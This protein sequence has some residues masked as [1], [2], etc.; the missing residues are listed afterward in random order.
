[1]T[2][3]ESPLSEGVVRLLGRPQ[4]PAA[5]APQVGVFIVGPD[6]RIADAE[7]SACAL[8]GYP[9]GGLV[10]RLLLDLTH[11]DDRQST[12]DTCLLLFG[13]HA[14][15]VNLQKRFLRQDGT[16]VHVDVRV[17]AIPNGEG[18]TTG[19]IVVA[20]PHDE[21][22]AAAAE[23]AGPLAA[24]ASSGAFDTLAEGVEGALQVGLACLHMD[25]A[26]VSRIEGE[27]GRVLASAGKAPPA[28]AQVRRAS[29][30]WAAPLQAQGPALVPDTTVS[31][32]HMSSHAGFPLGSYAGLL[33]TADGHPV[34]VDFLGAASRPAFGV[35]DEEVLAIV[36]RWVAVAVEREAARTRA[37]QLEHELA[38]RTRL[39]GHATAQLERY[40]SDLAL[41]LDS[42]AEGIFG[43]D[44]EGRITFAN[45]A[46]AG[47]LGY[48]VEEL[49]GQPHHALFH[50]SR[51]DGLPLQRAS[52]AILG[53]LGGEVTRVEAETFW[54]KDG[55]ALPVSIVSA[56][57]R[58][59]DRVTGAA[60][61]FNDRSAAV[62]AER[63]RAELVHRLE[64]F[65]EAIP[66]GVFIV[67]AEQRPTFANA[68]AQ[69]LL[70]RDIGEASDFSN[71]LATY[72]AFREGTDL[73]Y[74]REELPMLRALAGERHATCSDLEL[75]LPDRTLNLEVWAEPIRGPDGRLSF[76]VT[77]FQDISERRAD[78][79]RRALEGAIA[80]VLASAADV[81]DALP[82]LLRAMLRHLPFATA[83]FW[84]VDRSSGI[85]RCAE[86]V[87]EGQPRYEALEA[88]TRRATP[89][90][91]SG[92]VGEAWR[93]G[94]P[95]S[96][97][98]EA[99]HRTFSRVREADAAGIRTALA[100]PIL[101]EGETIAV[102][103]LLGPK[104]TRPEPGLL[105]S[106]ATAGAQVGQFLRRA[107]VQAD[108]RAMVE[109][110]RDLEESR[111]KVLKTVAHDL[112]GPL[113]PIRLQLRML[114]TSLGTATPAQAKAFKTIERNLSQMQRLV[115]DVKD[116]ARLQS[117]EITLQPEGLDLCELARHAAE[118]FRAEAESK[119]IRISD[120]LSKPMPVH[121]DAQRMTQVLFNLL[122]NALKFT[123]S[124][125][126]ITVEGTAHAGKATV[127]VRDTGRGLSREES[128]RLFKAFSQVH[129]RATVPERG[130]GLG[131]Y[132]CK[133]LLERHG[134]DIEVSSPGPG[135]GSTFTFTLPLAG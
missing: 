132:I 7:P 130:S 13:G 128:A 56:P 101:A 86:F 12:A 103:E 37:A 33:V 108:L 70:G 78:E 43:I 110:I 88:A 87:P 40:R 114:Q 67:D 20:Q 75:R 23:A 119:G 21:R 29:T 83:A 123:P 121:A 2:L 39:H 109:R 85:M 97:M 1:M 19:A 46:C 35:A 90:R 5:R 112:G 134:G 30:M 14:P 62:A 107:Q 73:P 60:V 36:G 129:D 79:R 28:G 32:W 76:A 117:G 111:M 120:D 80:Q 51:T 105:A 94:E 15:V 74:P 17:L 113:V 64:H 16:S 58:H 42:A 27:S 102:M 34:V 57:L 26:M 6:N 53:A 72:H 66:L 10:G 4:A 104:V 89:T 69:R 68:A 50:H 127:R 133:G 41:L 22:R 91:G 65:L 124:G 81:R 95:L 71:V 77:A 118:S 96:V 115:E 131:L 93:R 38:E 82:R 84:V 48:K 98:G 45:P 92:F 47:L 59:G 44:T 125:G 100:V 25:G 11:P 52:C 116:L 31:P 55:S 126:T 61:V 63:E 122:S 18:Q 99:F 24:A 135:Q 3:Q 54:R 8:L 49:S 9:P 106:L